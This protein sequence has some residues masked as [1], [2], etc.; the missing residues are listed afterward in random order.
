MPQLKK[1]LHAKPSIK[2]LCSRY[3]KIKTTGEKPS[4]ISL[5]FDRN[6]FNQSS[7]W[8]GSQRRPQLLK[9]LQ[10]PMP[11]KKALGAQTLPEVA[12]LHGPYLKTEP[13]FPDIHRDHEG[14]G[15]LGFLK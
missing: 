13:P 5:P 2:I 9:S 14:N 10:L 8:S 1:R 3:Q 12:D 15:E 4:F 6:F 11:M 7:Q